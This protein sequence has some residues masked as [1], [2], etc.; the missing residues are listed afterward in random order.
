LRYGCVGD[1]EAHELEPPLGDVA[2]GLPVVDDVPQATG[3]HDHHR[4]AVEVVP[5]LALGDEHGAEELLDSWVM[6][7]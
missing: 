7:L 1:V 3:G 4:V 5:E 2:D 6:G